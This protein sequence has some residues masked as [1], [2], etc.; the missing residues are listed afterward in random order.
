MISAQ[1]SIVT[2]HTARIRTSKGTFTVALFGNDAPRTVQNFIGLARKGRYNNVLFHRIAKGFVIQTGDPRTRNSKKRDEWGTGGESI[3]GKPFD[4]E[5]R[6]STPSYQV[7]YIRGTVAMANNGP[8]TNTSQF[9][10]CLTDVPDLAKN[11]TIFG[12]VIEGMA[13]VDSIGAVEIEP[14]L[15]A[16]DGIPVEPVAI[17]SVKVATYRNKP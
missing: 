10:I 5:L 6:P 12:K 13:T 14:V 9:F 7:G 17:H 11:F 4:D 16:T 3:Y 15:D 1:D 8:N 2:T